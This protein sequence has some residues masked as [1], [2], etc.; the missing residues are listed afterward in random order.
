MSSLAFFFALLEIPSKASISP[1]DVWKGSNSRKC[2]SAVGTDTRA[3]TDMPLGSGGASDVATFEIV[4][5]VGTNPGAGCLPFVAPT[6]EFEFVRECEG[7]GLA[8][9]CDEDEADRTIM[10][11]VLL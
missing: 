9:V 1:G 5:R 2:P 10:L 4:L 11:L 7:S 8:P 6:L 3:A